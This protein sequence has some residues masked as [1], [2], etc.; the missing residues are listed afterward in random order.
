MSL[1]DAIVPRKAE[2]RFH[3]SRVA[4][5]A[6]DKTAHFTHMTP[7]GPLAPAV[8]DLHPAFFEHGHT[9]LASQI[10]RAQV[11]VVRHLLHLVL[12]QLD[13]RFADGKIIR[14]QAPREERRR[15]FAP[16][17]ASRGLRAGPFLGVGDSSARHSPSKRRSNDSEPV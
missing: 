10:D 6:V 17:G 1:H 4:T 8:Q 7:F 16:S 3:R 13:F 15:F 11:L 12:V 2:S 5:N 14:K 9:F